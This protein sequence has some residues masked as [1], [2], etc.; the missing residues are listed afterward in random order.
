MST[1]LVLFYVLLFLLIVGYII[2]K[3]MSSRKHA[4]LQKF[5]VKSIEHKDEVIL[6]MFPRYTFNIPSQSP[7]VIKLE[8]FLRLYKI[9]YVCD[10]KYYFHP[11]T[12]KTPWIT[13]NGKHYYDSEL[14]VEYLC[15]YFNVDINQKLNNKQIATAYSMSIMI[16]KS[17]QY[18]VLYKY[19]IDPQNGS[20][21][22][23]M[24]YGSEKNETSNNFLIK[25]IPKT[26][27][28]K[29]IAWR[30]YKH[31]LKYLQSFY[32]NGFIGNKIYEIGNQQ[33]NC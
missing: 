13:F 27:L 4:D 7:F 28:H 22:Q 14:I 3:R 8:S 25:I 18:V 33:I 11:I 9:K 31:H 24:C 19:F 30:T 16:Q 2:K 21:K 23:F 26:I 5:I 17:L 1:L 6:H 29:I 12:N 32:G 20:A 15:K 10:Y